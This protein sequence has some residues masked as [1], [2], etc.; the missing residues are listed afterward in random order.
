MPTLLPE[1]SLCSLQF[2]FWMG[3]FCR[4]GSC[5]IG[6]MILYHLLF[7]AFLVVGTWSYIGFGLN[8]TPILIMA[9]INRTLSLWS[10]V[11]GMSRRKSG[12]STT[13]PWQRTLKQV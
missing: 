13:V 5:L 9:S 3:E 7:T 10:L 4:A 8:G 12:S 1:S 11:I 6:G 2:I